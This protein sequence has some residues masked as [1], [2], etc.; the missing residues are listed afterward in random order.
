MI[1][2]TRNYGYKKGSQ[3]SI[4]NVI[5]FTMIR[6]FF[7]DRSYEE[8]RKEYFIRKLNSSEIN[9]IMRDIKLLFKEYK[10]LDVITIENKKGD[11]TKIIL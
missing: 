4:P 9:Q 5:A 1:I 7:S 3:S 6:N 11:I 2:Y 8:M 10:G